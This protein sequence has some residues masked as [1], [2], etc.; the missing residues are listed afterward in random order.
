MNDPNNN[1]NNNNMNDNKDNKDINND[2]IET[3]NKIFDE[4][5]KKNNNSLKFK[6]EFKPLSK[7]SKRSQIIKKDDEKN[8]S[9]ILNNDNNNQHK[10]PVEFE[11]YKEAKT[12]KEKKEKMEYNNMMNI[13]LNAQKVKISNN[14]HKIAI[15]KIEREI[16]ETIAKYE[17]NNQ[18]SFIDAG[19]ILADLKIFREMFKD[20]INNNNNAKKNNNNKLHKKIQSY[21]DI[22]HELL[23]QKEK[24]ER[25]QKEINF[26]EQLWLIINPNNIDFIKTDIFSETLKILFTP[27]N[28]NYK[29]I[30]EIL[31]QFLLTAFFLN[32]NPND[33]KVYKSPITHQDVKEELIWD[34]EKLVK[35][36]LLLKENLL[37]YKNI[38]H[39]S[40][41]MEKDIEDNKKNICFKPKINNNNDNNNND[42]TYFEKRLEFLEQ[43]KNLREKVLNEMRKDN[44]NKEMEEC[45]FKPKINKSYT[46]NKFNTNNNILNNNNSNNNNINNNNNN[47]N[48]WE[49]LYKSNEGK[50]ERLNE[51]KNLEKK[52][53]EEKELEQCT[54][55]PT[56][57]SQNTLEQ[58]LNSQVKPKGYEEFS[59]KM[60]EGIMKAAEKKYIENKI[61]IGE[62]YEKI[63]NKKI[64]PFNITDLKKNNKK[65]NNNNKNENEN[66]NNNKKTSNDFFTI[67]IKIP[68][69]KER[70][71]K[72]FVNEDPYDIANNFCKT[73]GLK[74]E[75]IER[76]AKTIL[77]FRN[78]YLQKNNINNNENI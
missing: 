1:D 31:K 40:K 42:N 10:I 3:F 78:L 61:P 48:I 52:M 29:E 27:V 46:I 67:Q 76:L 43:R 12:R 59:R 36:F 69:G 77:N 71:I 22:Q 32:S 34:T 55:K 45:T 41:R 17:N 38:K 47:N 57:I 9:N 2:N 54:F 13:L 28:P 30:S 56:L 35:E 18:I 26:Y 33:V 6:N 58:C 62:N 4:I 74:K 60:R 44:E 20:D 66:N 11:L 24:E 72:V 15:N 53:E 5:L 64:L 65:N 73:Y 70:M 75:V 25:K 21:K 49:K 14:S 37:A 7:M 19:K 8:K 23:T 50:Y 16:D 51:L 63:K 68:N 39:N